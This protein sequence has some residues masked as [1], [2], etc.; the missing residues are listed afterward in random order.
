MKNNKANQLPDAKRYAV[1][2]EWSDDDE[3]FVARV[4][5]L[6]GCLCVMPTETA[7]LKEIRGLIRE[8]LEIKHERG[9]AIPEPDGGLEIVRGLLPIVNVSKL[10][11]AAGV[12]RTTL[13]SRL[14]RGTPMPKEDTQRVRN[15][16][17]ELLPA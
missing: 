16:I 5:A 2:I 1:R 13:T 12:N 17:A 14:H 9:S 15:V 11:R 4:P 7:A 8:F 3:G 6:P 10:A